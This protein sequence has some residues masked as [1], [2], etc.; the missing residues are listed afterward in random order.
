L[1]DH[2][3][4]HTAQICSLYID[5]DQLRSHHNLI[6]L[7]W[8]ISK[9]GCIPHVSCHPNNRFFFS[10]YLRDSKNL[11]DDHLIIVSR[12]Q[13]NLYDAYLMCLVTHELIK[14]TCLELGKKVLH[15]CLILHML[16][17]DHLMLVEVGVHQGS[18]NMSHWSWCERT[19]YWCHLVDSTD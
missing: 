5:Q 17:I 8:K 10:V 7:Q 11:S 1:Q 4:S 19:Q 6:G 12:T 14:A 18:Q 16:P 13:K 15:D 3:T 2:N 9:G